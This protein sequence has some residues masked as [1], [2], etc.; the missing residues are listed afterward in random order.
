MALQRALTSVLVLV[1][2]VDALSSSF[3]GRRAPAA[4]GG[5]AMLKMDSE[6]F[7]LQLKVDL[8]QIFH[9]SS[10]ARLT[11]DQA[12][13]QYGMPWKESIDR[14]AFVDEDLLYMRF[15]QWQMNFMKENLTNLRVVSCKHENHDFSYNENL[16]KKARIVNLCASSHEYRKI[17]LTYYDAGDNCQVFNAVWYPDPK[18]NLPVL[19]I[20]LLAFNRKKYLAIVDFQPIHQD[21]SSHAC[22]FEHLLE[23]IKSKY[24]SLKGQMSSKFYDETQ[25]FSKQMLFS[26]FDN[27]KIIDNELFPAFKQYV[28]THLQM[29]RDTP[30]EPANA[31]HVLERQRAYDTYSAE[32]DP[33]AG[34]F[35][36]MFGADWADAF[37]HNFLFSLS[38]QGEGKSQ[39]SVAFMGGPPSQQ[40]QDVHQREAQREAVAVR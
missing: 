20:D 5:R 38:E 39:P 3:L 11:L 29:V 4:F 30:A 6:R 24:D 23:P 40:K 35:C 15:W 1:Y 9:E 31:D 12:E 21:E 33:A 28:E 16:K 14:N 27:E 26:R 7:D 32:R 22:S 17:R 8:D 36:A 37:M 10:Q 34:L 19:G 13:A 25:F 2:S 18:Y